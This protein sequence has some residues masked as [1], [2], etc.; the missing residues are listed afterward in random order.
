MRIAIDVDPDTL[1]PA[2]QTN[3]TVQS[4]VDYLVE[5]LVRLQ[6]DGSLAPGLA[7]K[8]ER[9]PDGRA[10]TFSL[11]QGVRF[12]DR[13]ILDA[14]AV[15]L[16]LDR[17]LNPQLK[18]PLRAPFDANLVEA[19]VVVDPSTV[20]VQL[21]DAFRLFLQKL[22]GTEMGIVSPAHAHAYPD[23]YNEEPAGTGPYR[24]KERRRGESVVLERFENYWGRKPYYPQVQFRIVPEVATRE[25]LL[26]ANQVDMIIQPPL[27]DIPA[28]QR[29]GNLRVLLGPTSR[30]TFVAMDLTLPGGTPLGIKKVRQALNYAIDRDG[31]IRTLL[32]GAAVPM[33]APMAPSLAGYTRVG[34]YPYDPGRAKQLLMEGG[35][36]QL[37]LKFIHPTGRSTQDALAAQVAQGVA[38]NLHEVGVTCELTGYDWPSYLAA[39][40]VPEDRGIAHMHLFGWA[41]AFLDASQQ[42]T[43]FTRT[44]WP[45][46]GLATSHY[47]N[48]RVETLLDQSNTEADAQKRQELYAEAQR[49]IWDDAPWIFL[50]V[51]SFP[52]AHTSRLAGITTSASEKFSAVYAEPT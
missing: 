42:L 34:P 26:L 51:P 12:H 37:L 30:T 25:S 33:D 1:D 40:N 49:L 18:V 10:Y 22:A 21:K 50:W 16:S 48:P 24:F 13:A 8:W 2:G 15:K 6:P 47:T 44:Q 5:P 32:F 3:A 35:T 39:I 20:R 41:P 31:L 23:S 36:P 19:V 45:P 27:S 9:S 11:R 46:Q 38:S 29:S 7:E 14:D 28:L 43:Q 52:L 4:V 17:F